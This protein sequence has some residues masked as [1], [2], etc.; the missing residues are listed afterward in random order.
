MKNTSSD[1]KKE[2]RTVLV[3]VMIIHT[4]KHNLES[5]LASS[6]WKKKWLR[7][8]SSSKIYKI[9]LV[10][11]VL[12]IRLISNS[13]HR[14]WNQLF[15]PAKVST[16][17]TLVFNPHALPTMHKAHKVGDVPKMWGQTWLLFCHR[18]HIMRMLPTLELYTKQ[19]HLNLFTVVPWWLW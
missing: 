17:P 14:N 15:S 13:V 4:R 2:I 3:L 8:W 18:P 16:C 12:Q 9:N 6:L 19:N 7:F 1:S 11:R 10:D 5:R